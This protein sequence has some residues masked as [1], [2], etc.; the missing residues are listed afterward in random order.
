M[1][2][3]GQGVPRRSTAGLR[4]NLVFGD[5]GPST[6]FIHPLVH[7]HSV[8]AATVLTEQARNRP[9]LWDAPCRSGV[10]ASC[11]SS[12]RSWL[13]NLWW[14]VATL[15]VIRVIALAPRI[16]QPRHPFGRAEREH[17]ARD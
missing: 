1:K 12:S 2:L 8:A 6:F 4:I 5:S 16:A 14:E 7:R 13:L 9:L 17:G 15:I 3:T 11:S 10:R